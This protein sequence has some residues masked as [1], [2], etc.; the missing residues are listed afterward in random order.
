M[1]EKKTKRMAA[2]STV[3][4][5]EAWAQPSLQAVGSASRKPACKSCGL[6]AEPEAKKL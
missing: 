4:L 5:F 1:E 6:A 3:I 2:K